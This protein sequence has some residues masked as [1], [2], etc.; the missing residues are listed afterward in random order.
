MRQASPPLTVAEAANLSPTL[1]QLAQAA[2]QSRTQLQSVEHLIPERLRT[3]VQAGP[4]DNG[5]WCLLVRGN[6]AAAKMRQLLPTIQAQLR[7]RGCEVTAIRL[8]VQMF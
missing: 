3:S 1:A 4:L 7:E 2:Q 8:K 5:T 6:A